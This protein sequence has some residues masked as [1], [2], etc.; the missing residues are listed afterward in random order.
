MEKKTRMKF[1]GAALLLIMVLL[2]IFD[3][4]MR[5]AKWFTY[6]RND[7][8]LTITGIQG[9]H[10]KISVPEEIDG[11][12]VTASTVSPGLESANIAAVRAWVPL[13]KFIRTNAASV[14]K[15]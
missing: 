9:V 5:P 11:V 3:P 8:G 2:I 1:I 13:T 4:V 14:P 6:E 15:T 7:T 12:P 10:R